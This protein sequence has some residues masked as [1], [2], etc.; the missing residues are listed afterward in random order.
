[1]SQ[2]RFLLCWNLSL[3]EPGYLWQGH[4]FCVSADCCTVV[5]LYCCTV[6]TCGVE[7]FCQIFVQLSQ[8]GS[9]LFRSSIYRINKFL[10]STLRSRVRVC[11]NLLNPALSSGQLEAREKIL[12]NL[13]SDK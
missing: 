10:E 4:L 7:K 8:T 1:M 6:L 3:S 9:G 2:G 13:S 11:E 5:L 12:Q